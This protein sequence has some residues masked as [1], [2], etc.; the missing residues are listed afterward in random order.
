MTRPEYSPHTITAIADGI[1]FAERP[2]PDANLIALPGQ[3]PAIIDSGFAAHAGATADLAHRA[4]ETAPQHVVNT[5]WHSDHVGG[6]AV[7]QAAGAQIVGSAGDAADLA[8]PS[9]GCCSAEY[10]DQPVP[11]YTVDAAARDGDSLLLGDASWT[12]LEVPGHT[13]GHLALW[14]EDASVLVVGDTLSAHDVGWVDVMREGAAG[15]DDAI[16]SVDRLTAC[17]PRIILPGHGPALVAGDESAPDPASALAAARSRLQRQREDLPLAVQYGARRIL[18]FALLIRDGI[19]AD[20]I[21]DYVV[22]QQWTRAAAEAVG[23]RPEEFASQLVS[24]MVESGAVRLSAGLVT[25]KAPS[26]G[27]DP[28]VFELPWPRQWRHG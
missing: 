4:L 5:H 21:E 23:T 17:D 9:P 10:L 18:A 8:R 26:S 13:P 20:A 2:F 25:A 12:V 24:G 27:G 7:L 19:R 16:A 28:A 14:Q 15:L 22:S 6:N 3:A 11:A 1:R